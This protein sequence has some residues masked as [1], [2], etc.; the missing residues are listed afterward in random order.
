MAM[1]V[2][3]HHIALSPEEYAAV[4]H[5]LRTI[6]TTDDIHKT[7]RPAPVSPI[8][9]K[10]PTS[11]LRNRQAE[12]LS[13]QNGNQGGEAA[14]VSQHSNC[15]PSKWQPVDFSTVIGPSTSILNLTLNHHEGSTTTIQG[16]G[17]DNA[18][19]ELY[20]GTK[21]VS[22]SSSLDDNQAKDVPNAQQRIASGRNPFSKYSNTQCKSYKCK[23]GCRKD[24]SCYATGSET[25]SFA[26]PE[27]NR[28]YAEPKFSWRN[29]FS[30]YSNTQC[31]SYKCKAGCRK[32]KSCYA[33]GSETES[34]A[35]L[36]Q[37]QVYIEPD[38]YRGTQ[39]DPVYRG[40]QDDAVFGGP[41]ADPVYREPQDEPVYRETQDDPV[42][43]EPQDDPVYR[44]PQDDPVYREPQDDPVYR[45]TQDEP[46][47]REPQ[48]DPVYCE[49]QDDP[50]CRETQDDAV[51]RGSQDD[52]VYRGSRD[53]PVYP[54]T[55]DNQHFAE[56]EPYRGGSP[57]S[58]ENADYPES[59]PQ[60]KPV[61]YG[62][63]PK[64]QRNPNYADS[65]QDPVYH[66]GLLQRSPVYQEPDPSHDFAE[67][68]RKTDHYNEHNNLKNFLSIDTNY[69]D[70]S[71]VK[72]H[73]YD[74]NDYQ[75]DPYKTYSRASNANPESYSNALGV[76]SR[77]SLV[78]K[79][80]GQIDAAG[81]PLHCSYPKTDR[82]SM[83]AS[84]LAYDNPSTKSVTKAK[85]R[86]RK[87]PSSAQM[88][89]STTGF[90]TSLACPDSCGTNYA[91][92]QNPGS[93]CPRNPN[94]GTNCV[95]VE[96]FLANCKNFP[97]QCC[98]PCQGC[99]PRFPPPCLGC[100]PTSSCSPPK[101]ACNN[102]N[103]CFCM[104]YV[105]DILQDKSVYAVDY[106]PAMC[107]GNNFQ[108]FSNGNSCRCADLPIGGGCGPCCNDC[109]FGCGFTTEQPTCCGA[110]QTPCGGGQPPCQSACLYPLARL[111]PGYC[112]S[113]PCGGYTSYCM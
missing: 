105:C 103:E 101:S 14:A 27:Q 47:Y 13:N 96:S 41:Q 97:A 69:H 2:S 17:H 76:P 23:A 77:R 4:I 29:P 20:K 106:R 33:T 63:L 15:T 11:I 5:M 81:Q 12:D 50:V 40:N 99:C 61:Y 8:P 16:L 79:Q 22:S 9:Q 102:T 113:Y 91:Q 19:Q 67:S 100:C 98:D 84:A 43:R 104:G 95:D 75:F 39:D 68:H 87:R 90:K 18:V 70:E 28:V 88:G 48:N 46:V 94:A 26:R 78:P 89:S 25:E 56:A 53:N 111:S 64:L 42:Y 44:E 109:S 72:T 3:N 57:K 34:F 73:S 10:K 21:S 85:T 37:N 71:L 32:D 6:K 60:Q 38:V 31:K 65:E 82:G 86:G 54:S 112:N 55:R 52:P 7:Y 66:G 36:E 1:A 74:P 110:R 24:K 62:G 92:N 108:H 35:R 59:S 58:L 45:E 107:R 80:E 93:N 83:N 51:H 49:P 30:K